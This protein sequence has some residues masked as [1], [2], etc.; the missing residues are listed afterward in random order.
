M[1]ELYRHKRPKVNR[2]LPKDMI[3]ARLDIQVMEA[4][5]KEP[6]TINELAEMIYGYRYNQRLG[7]KVK[8]LEE[9]GL[10][11]TGKDKKIRLR[12]IDQ[13]SYQG[14]AALAKQEQTEGNP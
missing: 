11:R 2:G 12:S 13:V 8:Q 10:V 5:A 7:Y 4:I 3:G 1:V 14:R 9:D 6:M